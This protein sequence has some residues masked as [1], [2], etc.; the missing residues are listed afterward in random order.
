MSVRNLRVPV[1][2]AGGF[3]LVEVVA[4]I[5]LLGLLAAVALPR[6][7]D[8]QP[9]AEEASTRAQAAAL[10]SQDTINVAACRSGSSDC[11]DITTTGTQA[12]DEA[13]DEFFPHLDRSVFTVSN[14]DSNTP[15]EQWASQLDDGA[16][17][18]WVT[19]FLLTPPSDAW[20][21]QGWD[22]RQPCVLSRN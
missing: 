16:A 5:V 8:L 17:V 11:V 2:Y 6:F 19:R 4:V 1:L 14:I 18:F 22:V 21:G 3:T 9:E 12:C 13:I 10:I 20:L 7:I 15:A